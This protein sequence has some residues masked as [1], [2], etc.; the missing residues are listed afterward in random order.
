MI[1][2]EIIQRMNDI[3]STFRASLLML[4]LFALAG[5][6][7]DRVGGFDWFGSSS[8]APADAAKPVGAPPAAL[9]GRWLLSSPGRGQCHM[10]FGSAFVSSQG[11]GTRQ[12]SCA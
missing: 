1:G 10:T 3:R 11:T 8:P 2:D 4:G 5:C 9:Q 6:S 7:G 12:P